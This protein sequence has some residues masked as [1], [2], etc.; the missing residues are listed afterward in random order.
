MEMRF[1]C[2]RK[3]YAGVPA[4]DGVD[5][6]L[7]G[8][9]IHALMGENGAGK[10]TLIKLL[11]GVVPADDMVVER[12]GR[13]VSLTGPT[14]AHDHGFRFIHQELNIVPS[15]SVA[16]NI[17]LSH[18]FPRRFGLTV[19]WKRLRAGA[20][21]ALGFL[22]ADHIDPAAM[23][24][25]LGP[26]DRMLIKIAAALVTEDDG[27]APCLYVLDEPTAALSGQESEM[28]FAVLARLKG[29]GAAILYVSHRMDEVMRICDEVTVL[30]DGKRVAHRAVRDTTKRTIIRDMTGRDVSDAYPPRTTPIRD[31]VVAR[32]ADLHS[33]HLSGIG[34]ELRA[35]EI[36]GVTGLAEAGQSA[37]LGL[38][39]GR[40][41][42]RSGTLEALGQAA[43]KSPAQAWEAG[44]A[45]IPRERRGDGLMLEM[46]IRSNVAVSHLNAYGFW[47]SRTREASDTTEM[48]AKVRLKSSG[49]EQ[50]VGQLSGGN[51]QKVVFAR[52]LLVQPNLL[53]LDEPT[54]GVDV[55]AKFD[56]YTLVRELSASGCAVILTSTDLPEV[57]GMCDRIL[58][59]NEGRQTHL[60]PRGTMGQ[61]EL[62]DTFY[63]KEAETT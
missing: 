1:S 41:K 5:L 51:Q 62:L 27:Q 20:R 7:H 15:L 34:F 39:T 13:A 46:A 24:G 63:A 53:L 28:L 22:G 56:I 54:R 25:S 2:M 14:D 18:P 48:G 61:A 10:S 59:L 26:G 38:F 32:V 9:T 43:P 16:E 29:Q 30:R 6:T 3:A 19:H 55:G 33:P 47:A 58:V 8:G 36:L 23:A 40:E 60:L 12:D 17:L 52:A 45:S 4:L 35:G 50:P 31:T 57:L 21:D 44:I 11:A 37:L 49:P 42:R